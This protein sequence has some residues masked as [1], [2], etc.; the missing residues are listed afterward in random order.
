MNTDGLEL[1]YNKDNFRLFA[2]HINSMKK[3]VKLLRRPNYSLG[4]M[5]NYDFVN[6]VSLTTNYKYKGK[7]LDI[8]NSNWS[9]ISM[10]ETHLLDLSLTK[11]FYGINFGVTMSNVLDEKYQSPHGFSQDGRSFY[12]AL[13][14][15]F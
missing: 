9:T 1:S 15:N 2:S 13:S 10:P 6:D 7:H 14:S 11:T 8:H 4:F 12:F 3:N 5:H